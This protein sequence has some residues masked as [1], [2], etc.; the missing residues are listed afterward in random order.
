MADAAAVTGGQAMVSLEILQKLAPLAEGIGVELPS[1]SRVAPVVDLAQ[2]VRA[3]A[4]EL[5]NQ[6]K[7]QNIFLRGREVVTVD[8]ETGE[9]ELM[10]AK[11]L[12]G[13]CE[14]YVQFRV[15]A[16]S[17][18]MRNSMSREDA[19]LV[20][21]Q[22]IFRKALRPLR[23]VH[24]IRLPVVRADGVTEF[25]PVGYDA[26][27]EIFTVELLKYDMDWTLETANAFLD[28][29]GE[30]YPWSWPDETQETI[31]NNRSWCVIVLGMLGMFCRA[32]FPA[33]TPRPM[34]TCIGNKPGT[35]KSTLVAMM[36]APVWGYCA[37]TKVPKDEKDMSDEL[38][39]AA[40]NARPYLFFDDIGGGLF[41]N[42]LN[43]FITSGSRQGRIK[44]GNA[45]FRELV[46]TQVFATGNDIPVS[47]D[48]VRRSLIAELFLST[49]VRGRK[50]RRVITARY[51]MRDETRKG[52]LSALCALVRNA[53]AM[54]AAA[55]EAGSS[56]QETAGLESFEDFT[57]KLSEIMQLGGYA[58]PLI[59]PDLSSGGAETVD[60]MRELL[61]KVASE[62]KGDME[63][64][65]KELMEKARGFG[66]LE[67]LVGA[68]GEKDPDGSQMRKWGR[69]LQR[70]RGQEMTDDQGRRFRF[71]HKRQKRGAKYPL[72][73]I[74]TKQR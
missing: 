9:M 11:R 37:T 21:A 46:V 68:A 39:T 20:L 14:D 30:G 12:V 48:L 71:S 49:E 32:M 29:H 4:W 70:W 62:A 53:I 61:V 13:W 33:G 6:L 23:A 63:F 60:E 45:E 47:E 50:F 2:D 41:S 19:E 16:R 35:G 26:E 5:G 38:D 65:R 27:S 52:F 44:G 51:L 66:L 18:R 67:G 69:Q 73:F 31:R 36:V 17:Q 8:P 24:T 42:A 40:I 25:L 74:P 10:T 22:D 1:V 58:D 59:A 64:D 72:V 57:S 54:R 55:A 56:I 43:Q 3:L 15:P 28:E 34:I 7:R